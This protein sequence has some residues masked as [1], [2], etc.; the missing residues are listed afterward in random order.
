MPLNDYE[1]SYRGL[2]F[3]GATNYEVDE[4]SGIL[5]MSSRISDRPFPRMH[6]SLPGK[7]LA[8]SKDITLVIVVRGDM[9]SA[10]LASRI[11]TVMNAFAAGPFDYPD[12]DETNDKLVFKYPG[13]DEMFIRARPTKCT[14][15]GGRKF[16]TELGV[17]PIAIQMTAA[18]PRRYKNTEVDSGVKTAGFSVTNGGNIDA[19]PKVVFTTNGSGAA[20]ITNSTT[21]VA[22][23][24]SGCGATASVTADM[25]RLIRGESI[26][27]IVYEGST[28]RYVKWV[29]PRTPFYLAPGSNTITFDSGTNV[30]I[31]HYDA[32]V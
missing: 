9:G 1:F 14:L 16:A 15:V 6:G 7:H 22:L 26:N 19:W 23:E 4:E 32:Y 11:E 13:F 30:R 10:T 8:E 12:P 28:D 25:S 27:Y 18:D 17:R 31:Y 5:G 2:T 3:G 24:L 29:L 21:G 20:K